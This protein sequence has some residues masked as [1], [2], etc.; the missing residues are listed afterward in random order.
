MSTP[1]ADTPRATA[2]RRAPAARRAAHAVV[3]LGALAGALALLGPW[4][5]ALWLVPDLTLLA[6]M[7]SGP[8]E[9]GRLAPAAVPA[10]NAVHA[11]PGP[12]ALTLAGLLAG[13]AV[14]GAGVLW[15]SHVT[16]DRAMGY[17]L[18]TP[19]GEQRG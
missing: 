13:P 3:G 6:G 10:Y 9:Q 2:A 19:E 7:G 16:L 4:A 12:V 11:L 17:G 8:G 5:L 14:L 18:R 15:L 1:S